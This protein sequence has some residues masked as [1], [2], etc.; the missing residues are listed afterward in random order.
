MTFSLRQGGVVMSI[1][2]M[3]IQSSKIHPLAYI[4]GSCAL[5]FSASALFTVYPNHFMLWHPT[6]FLV[7]IPRA[8]EGGMKE[9]RTKQKWPRSTQSSTYAPGLSTPSYLS[10][11]VEQR[12]PSS[13]CSQRP[14]LRHPSNLTLVYPVP[15]IN[16]CTRA[17][18]FFL[19]F[20]HCCT[21]TVIPLLPK[22]TFTPSFQPNLC[23]PRTHHQ[24]TSAINTLLAIWCSTILSI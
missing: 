24:L 10:H 22:A 9:R 8:R 1:Q 17:L 5:I 16:I 2:I 23:L 3:P 13:L 12:P 18:L 20:A 21:A 4:P 6:S 19:S 14:P 15:T 11:I 7:I